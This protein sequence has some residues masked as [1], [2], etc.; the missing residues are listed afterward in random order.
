MRGIFGLDRLTEREKESLL[1]LGTGLGN[2][3]AA[4]A[5]WDPPLPSAA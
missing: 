3:H 2:R 1:L 5:A 4:T